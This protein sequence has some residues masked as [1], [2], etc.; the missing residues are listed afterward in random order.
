M[1]S[2]LISNYILE[3]Y[4]FLS[5]IKKTVSLVLSKPPSEPLQHT[6]KRARERGEMGISCLHKIITRISSYLTIKAP[7][8]RLTRTSCPGAKRFSITPKAILSI[9]S[10]C[11]SLSKGRAP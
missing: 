6:L 8:S 9:T 11:K 3:Y 1:F 7:P 10:R 5:L 4:M 2:Y